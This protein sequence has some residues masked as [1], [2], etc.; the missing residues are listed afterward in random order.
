[1]FLS[2]LDRRDFVWSDDLCYRQFLEDLIA[3]EP[4]ADSASFDEAWLTVGF[5]MHDALDGNRLAP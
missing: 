5:E 3:I 1:M 4:S 2:V